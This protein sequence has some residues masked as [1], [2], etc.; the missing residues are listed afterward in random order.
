MNKDGPTPIGKRGQTEGG[1]VER[2]GLG[3]GLRLRR[4]ARPPH[5]N[6]N[7]DHHPLK[8]WTSSWT[9]GNRQSVLL[10]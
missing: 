4:E 7:R 8:L 5:L 6:R 3:L 10:S 1:L 9:K 2:L